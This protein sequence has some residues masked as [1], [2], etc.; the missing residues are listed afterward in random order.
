[1]TIDPIAHID[2][3]VFAEAEFQI[4]NELL[5]FCSDGR[6]VLVFD[7]SEQEFLNLQRNP[8]DESVRRI[9]QTHRWKYVR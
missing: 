7:V 3:P 5:V 9:L 8:S 1:M 2:S 6:K 4:G